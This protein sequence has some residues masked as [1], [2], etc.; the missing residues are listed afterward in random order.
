MTL[1]Q[2][3]NEMPAKVTIQVAAKIMKVTP[4]FLHM[5]L[6][7]DRFP[8]GTAVKMGS[9]WSYYINTVRFVKYMDGEEV[10]YEKD[11]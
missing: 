4:R 7:Q 5:S 10:P 2:L 3:K 8:F 1:Q 6:Q 9:E 11:A